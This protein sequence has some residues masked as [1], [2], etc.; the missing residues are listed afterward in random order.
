MFCEYSSK[1]IGELQSLSKI[2]LGTDHTQ[3]CSLPQ[4]RSTCTVRSMSMLS[5]S[6]VCYLLLLTD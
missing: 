6:T 4:N 3:E 1:Q 5:R 2:I